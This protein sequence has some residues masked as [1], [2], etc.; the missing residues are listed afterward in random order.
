[1]ITSFYFWPASD[2]SCRSWWRH[3]HSLL[4]L[5]WRTK[6]PCPNESAIAVRGL[7]LLGCPRAHGHARAGRLSHAEAMNSLYSFVR[8]GRSCASS[9]SCQSQL[10]PSGRLIG[11]PGLGL[12]PPVGSWIFFT[13]E[14]CPKL[15]V[16]IAPVILW[17]FCGFLGWVPWWLL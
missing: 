9:S 6:L 7:C 16:R 12:A 1:M 3:G 14:P 15:G 2:F 8:S 10:L 11:A 13:P 17:A 5:L 4:W